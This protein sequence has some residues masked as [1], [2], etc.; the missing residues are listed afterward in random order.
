M[1]N[2]SGQLFNSTDNRDFVVIVRAGV[3]DV[4][5]R[6][7]LHG[8]EVWGTSSPRWGHSTSPW[9]KGRGEGLSRWVSLFSDL[10][11]IVSKPL[12]HWKLFVERGETPMELLTKELREQ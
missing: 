8:K 7:P 12:R 3:V 2:A 4:G 1:T 9:K 5:M 11:F 6:D 10:C